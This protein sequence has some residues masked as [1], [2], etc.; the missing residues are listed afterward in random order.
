[1]ISVRLQ[2]Q[3]VCVV[4]DKKEY[5][6]EYNQRPD[7]KERAKEYNQRPEVKERRKN[8]NNSKRGRFVK[9]KSRSKKHKLEFNLTEEY[10]ESI[11][12]EDDMCPLLNIQLNWDSDPKHP[13][14]PSLDRIDNN[15]GY[16]KGNVQWV[17]WRANNLM[18]DATPDE[19]FILAQNYKKIYNDALVAQQDRATDF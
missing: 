11:Y 19:L 3:E 4:S 15:K 5:M 8:W 12:P 16:I 9:L 7:V 1:M 18:K 2:V 14:K 6:V 13:S 10:L 17:S